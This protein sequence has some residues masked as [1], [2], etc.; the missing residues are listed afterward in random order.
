MTG[1][2]RPGRRH[3]AQG[4][5]RRR[6][7]RSLA[8]VGAGL[9]ATLGC[10]APSRAASVPDYR[11]PG[12]RDDSAAVL[13]AMDAASTI[14]FPA[15]QGMASDGAYLLHEV[16]L[17]SGS[18]VHGDGPGSVLRATAADTKAVLAAVSASTAAPLRD[19]VVR[20]LTIEGRVAQTGF[21]EH[22]NTFQVSG[23][24]GLKIERVAFVGFA[25]DGLCLCAEVA[26][27]VGRDPRV[28]RNVLVSDCLFDGVANDNRNAI[29]VTGGAD[30]TIDRCRFRR[31][32][33]P[34]MPGPIDFEPDPF[35]FY[36]LE[37]LRVTNCDFED[38]G[39]NVG[40]IAVIVPAIVPPPRGVL[41]AN[42]RFRRYRGSGGDIAVSINR[43][44]DAGTRPMDCVIERNTGTDG[45]GGIHLFSGRGITVRDNHWT[46]YSGRGFVGYDAPD[47]GVR[48]V[49]VSDR[50]DRCGWRDGVALAVYKG[51][52]VRLS[53]NRFTAT[54]N[55][56]AGS[57]PLY[58]GT[59]RI[60]RLALV[61]NDFRGNPDARGLIIVERGAD[62]LTAT[63]EVT[64]NLLPDKRRL[65]LQ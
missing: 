44:P 10:Q 28:I 60:R 47:A 62:Y 50:F 22:W 61:D 33:R 63:G 45:Y 36:R 29:S 46:G 41:I 12:D 26:H 40:Q 51:D 35:P 6:L 21:R 23:V 16:P 19:I 52:G 56:G 8:A 15:G 9:P 24:D 11:R 4:W 25:G 48:D 13:R 18:T 5:S 42:N 34:T 2:D 38:C 53:G 39:G 30:I 59:G 3:H 32:T 17:R 20:D 55:N 1:L 57:A 49:T 37:R 58:L 43:E 31:C 14:H 54:G 27:A 64:G 7:L 65:P